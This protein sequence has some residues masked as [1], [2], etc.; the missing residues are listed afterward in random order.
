MEEKNKLKSNK[1]INTWNI[2]WSSQIIIP[3]IICMLLFTF[4][5]PL[6][7]YILIPLWILMTVGSFIVLNRKGYKISFKVLI[8]AIFIMI[9]SMFISAS[10]FDTTVDGQWYHYDSIEA[11]RSGWNPLYNIGFD[12][13]ND[14]TFIYSEHYPKATWIFAAFYAIIFDTIELGKVYNI[15]SLLLLGGMVYSYLYQNKEK[16]SIFPRVLILL[17][18]ILNP[19]SIAQLNTFYADG[20]MGNLFIIYCIGVYLSYVNKDPLNTIIACIS[21]IMIINTKYTGLGYVGIIGLWLLIYILKNSKKDQYH[22]KKLFIPLVI[23]G[24]ISVLY[25]G[26]DSYVRNT[27]DHKHPFYPIKG[28]NTIDIMTSNTPESFRYDG[29]IEK[30]L[31]S[32]LSKTSSSNETNELKN[33][34]FISKDEFKQMNQDTRIAGFGPMFAL[35]A[36]ISIISL[37]A[38]ILK[39]GSIKEVLL[40]TIPLL[41]TVTIN[42]ENWWAR[43]VPQ[44]WIIPII[45]FMISMK[46][47]N[48]KTTKILGIIGIMVLLINSSVA[49]VYLQETQYLKSKEQKQV[50]KSLNEYD[51]VYVEL[52]NPAMVSLQHKFKL[53]N[54]DSI[55]VSKIDEQKYHIVEIPYAFSVNIAV[56]K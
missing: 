20:W 18:V 9:I 26:F 46:K 12:R 21:I 39:E 14:P 29:Y 25:I 2:W 53:L 54:I 15:Y 28:E 49:F 34:L 33:P 43:Y 31:K 42:P 13:I 35:G 56:S 5:I 8:I 40:L 17:C 41:L 48:T 7:K 30:F 1:N 10:I 38:I 51:E 36:I 6:N 24:M 47:L 16:I 50:I 44:L 32:N 27:F 52:Q 45:V 3:L 37:L 19:I 4:K 55:E 22:W 11:I 23:C